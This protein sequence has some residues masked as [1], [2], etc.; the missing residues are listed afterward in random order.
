M[1]LVRAALLNALWGYRG[2]VA[3]TCISVILYGCL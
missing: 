1:G 3:A 2:R